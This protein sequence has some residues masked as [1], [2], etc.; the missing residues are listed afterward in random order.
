MM[1]F[2][3]YDASSAFALLPQ[4]LKQTV[5]CPLVDPP[6]YIYSDVTH[7]EVCGKRVHKKA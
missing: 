2:V 3:F 7:K 4:K 1:L 5:S 6:L